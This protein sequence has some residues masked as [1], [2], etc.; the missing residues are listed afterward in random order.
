[1]VSARI[2]LIGGMSWESTASYYR[3]LNES[4]VAGPSEWSKPDVTIDSI[5]FGSIVALQRRGDWASTGSILADSARRLVRA[6]A[7][8]LAIAANT[9]HINLDDVRAAVDV[10]VVDVREAVARECLAMGQS[11]IAL[12]GTKYLIEQSFYSDRLEELGVHCVRP[13]DEQVDRLQT[14]IF[15]E[16]VRG[17]VNSDSAI[18][19]RGVADECLARGA[20]VVGLCCTEFGMLMGENAEVPV[21]DSTRAHVRALL[22]EVR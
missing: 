9:M 16:L 6:G 13:T 4:F 3:Y 10:P 7:T 1:V 17:V 2:G 8:V 21:I 12:L 19:L 14:I 11:S 15:D 18:Y 22:A 5:D 20:G